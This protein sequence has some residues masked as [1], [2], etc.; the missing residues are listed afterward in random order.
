M[1]NGDIPKVGQSKDE[2]GYAVL[3]TLNG[4][5]YLMEV[6]GYRGGYDD[7]TL[8]KLAKKAKQWDIQTVVHES[9][10]G[11]GMFGKVFQST[12][13]KHHKCSMEEIRA[14]GMKELRI[15]DTIEPLMGSHRLVIRDEVIREDY[16]TARDVDGKHDVRYSAF[17]QMT[18][19]TREK[20]AVAHDDRV[21]ALAL[22]IEWL[23]EGMQV[24]SKI[25]EEEMTLEFLEH[26]MEKA[27]VGGEMAR[28]LTS[29]GVDIYY[30]DDGD[31]VSFMGW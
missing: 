6:G 9:N 13:L 4:Y 2:T 15:C 23:R 25:G 3:Y 11:D 26:H 21:D 22:G 20:G 12:L 7:P 27:I 29:G 28:E 17:Y 18:R 8:E 10:F 24:D 1:V 16:Q 5:I 30:E 19:M 14:R 31:G